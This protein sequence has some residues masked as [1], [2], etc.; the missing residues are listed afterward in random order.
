MK[1]KFKIL[2]AFMAI[3]LTD[4]SSWG[5][6]I[7]LSSI[8]DMS[9]VDYIVRSNPQLKNDYSSSVLLAY[10]VSSGVSAVT[11]PVGGTASVS[12]PGSY[13]AGSPAGVGFFI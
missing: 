8:T 13:T 10:P 12:Y 11:I 9:T 2:I 3:F 4:Y 1:T 5:Q 6:T 7:N